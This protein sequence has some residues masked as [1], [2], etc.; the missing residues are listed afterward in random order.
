MARQ[1][2]GRST[3][4]EVDLDAV[5]LAAEQRARL[6]WQRQ[7]QAA[8]HCI[9]GAKRKAQLR[10]SAARQREVV[11]DLRASKALVAVMAKA[12]R[13]A[14]ELMDSAQL[15]AVRFEVI[16]AGEQLLA[17]RDSLDAVLVRIGGPR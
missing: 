17:G 2:T 4:H 8:K 6:A 7:V 12:L 15:A 13:E 11:N 16:E 5:L 3:R 1:F 10:A 9:G 14:R